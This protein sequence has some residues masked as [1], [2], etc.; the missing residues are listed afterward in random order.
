MKTVNRLPEYVL[1]VDDSDVQ[2][3]FIV[4]QCIAL[5]IPRIL[6]AE[7]GCDALAQLKASPAIEVIVLDLEMPGMDGVEALHEMARLG[8]NPA[9]ILASARDSVLLNVVE[10]MGRSLGLHLLGALQKPITQE[11]LLTSL[12]RFSAVEPCTERQ[13]APVPGPRVD[14]HEIQRALQEKEF[15]AYFQPKVSLLDGTLTGVEALI[16]W[17]HP[18]H[19]LLTPDRFIGLIE[20]SRHMA[21]TTLQ[22]LDLALRHCRGWHEAGLP[23]S[24]SINVSADTLADTRLAE[25]II[26]RVASSGIAPRFV[27]L[28]ITESAIMTDLSTTLGTLAR[29]RLKG[30]GLSVDDYGTGF[31]CMLQLSRVPCSELKIDRAFVNGASQKLHLRVLL[32]SALDIARKLDLRVVAEGVESRDDWELL[33][34]LGCTEAQ[35]YFIAKP[36]PGDALPAWWRAN[37]ERLQAMVGIAV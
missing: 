34:Q 25:A 35:G 9:V 2:R 23:L 31:S 27:I 21:E 12:S 29:L 26:A 30:F 24:C 10:N 8:L 16:R 19:G 36:M 22:M 4:D 17:Q 18:T 5:G 1:I 32:E 14:E 3:S 7:D 11:Q 6:Q 13:A 33:C 15:V 37:Q 20:C 28:E